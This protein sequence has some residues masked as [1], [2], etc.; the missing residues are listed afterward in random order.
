VA[1]SPLGRIR[2]IGLRSLALGYLGLVLAAPLT[3][4]F[5]RA[6]AD[7]F[8]AFWGAVS[9]PTAVHALWLTTQIT[10]IA[11]PLNTLF[12]VIAALLIVRRRVPGRT[13]LTTLIDLP[14]ALSPVVVG[15]SV[16]L[17]WGLRG[18]WGGWLAEHG[19]R[20]V[21]AMPGMVIATIIVCLPFVVREVV[22]VLREV[23]TDQEEA[24]TVLGASS[25]Q[26][27]LRVTLPAIR[28]G[29]AYGVVLTTA[30]ALGEYGAV[31]VVS[32]RIQG[33]TQTLTLYVDDRHT[34]FD[35]V[36]AYGAAV[37]LATLSLLT[38]LGMSLFRRGDDPAEGSDH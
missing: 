8:G 35:E 33:T 23:G 31:A 21:F 25:V 29:V 24:A 12:G 13:I 18:W 2:R 17:V 6:F 36:G 32:G 9:S 28:W 30:R 11:V 26:T 19:V 16:V 37:V 10:L 5:W 4:I 3:L 14:L 7:G 1:A 27:F 38:V 22:P 15:L 34:S 20:V